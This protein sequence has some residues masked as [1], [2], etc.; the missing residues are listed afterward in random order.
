MVSLKPSGVRY[1]PSMRQSSRSS[2]TRSTASGALPSAAS[3]ASV[4]T[5]DSIGVVCVNLIVAQW[6]AVRPQALQFLATLGFSGQFPGRQAYYLDACAAL[7]PPFFAHLR[8]VGRLPRVPRG[9]RTRLRVGSAALQR[10][11]CLDRQRCVEYAPEG[12]LAAA[13]AA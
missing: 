5:G 4:F 8:R 6:R 13:I 10:A 3:V 2:S 12:Q 7:T 9:G 1:S 11:F